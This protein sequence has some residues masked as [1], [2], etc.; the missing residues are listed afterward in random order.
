M[1]GHDGE[2]EFYGTD[3]TGLCLRWHVCVFVRS[4]EGWFGV[5]GG[6]RSCRDGPPLTCIV[7]GGVRGVGGGC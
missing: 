2:G 6:Q 4:R 5:T 1:Q 3:W 7:W